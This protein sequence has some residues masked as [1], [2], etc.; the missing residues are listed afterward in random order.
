[1]FR[2]IAVVTFLVFMPTVAL[3]QQPANSPTIKRDTAK[4]TRSNDGAQMYTEYCAVCHGKDGKGNGPAAAALKAKP[5]D[6]TQLAKQHNGEIS[7]KDF[8]D[9]VTGKL[10]T[11]AHGAADMPIWGPVFSSLGNEQLRL[12][13]VRKYVESLQTK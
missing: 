10:M 3:A 11:P 12:Y 9:K 8:E 1:M 5:A 13:N 2:R 7:A 4:M 6:L